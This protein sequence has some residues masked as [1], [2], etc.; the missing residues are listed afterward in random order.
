MYGWENFWTDRPITNGRQR[1]PDEMTLFI[2]RSHAYLDQL[3]VGAETA[4]HRFR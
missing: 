1:T 2:E 4:W 3:M